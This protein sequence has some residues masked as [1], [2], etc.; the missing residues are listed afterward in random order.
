MSPQLE[1]IRIHQLAHRLSHTNDQR[2]K[3][4][5]AV[6]ILTLMDEFKTLHPCYEQCYSI[7]ASQ[8]HTLTTKYDETWA[9][10][11]LQREQQDLFMGDEYIG[12][13]EKASFF[14][15]FVPQYRKLFIGCD[16][17]NLQNLLNKV[18][19]SVQFLS[20]CSDISSFTENRYFEFQFYQMVAVL[21]GSMWFSSYAKHDESISQN[22]EASPSLKWAQIEKK[23]NKYHEKTCHFSKNLDERH[24]DVITGVKAEFRYYGLV[25]WL[26]AFAKLKEHRLVEFCED[27]SALVENAEALKQIGLY[28]GAFLCYGVASI[29]AKPFKE[30]D[31]RSHERVLDFYTANKSKGAELYAI[32]RLLSLAKF[33]DVKPLWQPSLTMRL[34]ADIA[35]CLPVKTRGTFWDF[36]LSVVDF[37]AFL[38]IMSISECIP[39]DILLDKLGYKSA[40]ESKRNAVANN[41]VMVISVLDLGK[42]NVFYDESEATF[43]HLAVDEKI[44][45]LD[46]QDQIENLDHLANAEAAAAHMK[47]LLVRKYFS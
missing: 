43:Y 1:F 41:L 23:C 21:Y 15:N 7:L 45:K 14:E 8:G 3:V 39:K 18:S 37:K 31:F 36:L 30:L 44:R 38:L 27:F 17:A 16:F 42:A 32:T 28:T 13:A 47:T 20:Q 25:K 10:S 6:S 2:E 40:P 34:D 12:Q 4:D 33:K 5:S 9:C 11:V 35:F 22:D 46:L 26:C 24:P 19:L 29:A